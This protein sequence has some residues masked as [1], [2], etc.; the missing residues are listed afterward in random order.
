MK[1]TED[2]LKAA[3]DKGSPAEQPAGATLEAMKDAEAETGK[4]EAEDEQDVPEWLKGP[5]PEMIEKL[6]ELGISPD[7]VP[8]FRALGEEVPLISEI[9]GVA[10]GT[11]NGLLAEKIKTVAGQIDR[12]RVSE[13]EPSVK[14]ALLSAG[15]IIGTDLRSVMRRPALLD[16][17]E[18][19]ASDRKAVDNSVGAHFNN[20]LKAAIE[21]EARDTADAIAR[22]SQNCR[23]GC[24]LW[25]PGGPGRLSSRS[26]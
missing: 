20:D 11:V 8:T 18:R 12:D 15:G 4:L 25:G 22:F 16:R 13:R 9:L 7:R 5:G 21:A 26:A 23:S 3:R 6:T 24:R 19:H 2:D 17:L 14:A 10:F 1:K